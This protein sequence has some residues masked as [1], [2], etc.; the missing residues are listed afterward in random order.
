MFALLIGDVVTSAT[1]SILFL[2]ALAAEFLFGLI[3]LLYACHSFVL[4]VADTSAGNDEVFWPDEFLTDWI[5][6]LLYL[7]W[8]VAIWLV[9]TWLLLHEAEWAES[10]FVQTLIYLT[11]L[12]LFFPIGLLSSMS[13]S[14]F[15]VVVHPVFVWKL[16]KQGRALGIVYAVSALGFLICALLIAGTV[17]AG[18]LWLLPVMAPAIAA[19]WLIYARL[20]GR[21]AWVVNPRQPPPPKPPPPRRRPRYVERPAEGEEANETSPREDE[22]PEHVPLTF[23]ERQARRNQP[24]PPPPTRPLIDGVYSFPWYGTSLKAWIALTLGALL[25]GALGYL[26]VINWPK[27]EATSALPIGSTTVHLK[28]DQDLGLVS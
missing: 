17:F 26:V 5:G 11:V 12:W 13:V 21:L 8:L 7:L 10:P 28:L 25:M 24:A 23:A 14:M 27:E 22:P 19:A 3:I 15:W 16:A 18:W 4:V 6:K 2:A 9:P 20:L 1:H